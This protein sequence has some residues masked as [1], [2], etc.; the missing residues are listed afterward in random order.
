M[1]Y[2]SVS[3]ANPALV[4]CVVDCS[5]SMEDSGAHEHVF[6]AI[7]ELRFHALAKPKQIHVHIIGF[8]D[9]AQ[10][11]WQGWCEDF[12]PP[13][14]SELQRY[15][16]SQTHLKGACS[17]AVEAY[18]HHVSTRCTG[19]APLVNV[20]FFTDGFHSISLDYGDDKAIHGRTFIEVRKPNHWKSTTPDGLL[21]YIIGKPNV[22]LGLIDYS[23]T[24]RQFP[25]SG[26]SQKFPSDKITKTTI[27]EEGVLSK[28]YSRESVNPPPPGS[29]LV[30]IFGAMDNLLGK[31][32]IVSSDTI[33]QSPAVT[34]AFVR[35]GT[36][37][38][39]SSQN[40]N[41]ADDELQYRTDWN[42]E[43]NISFGDL[44]D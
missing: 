41:T 10:P 21:Q 18:K 2:D 28:A 33:L 44:E 16:G 36:S 12:I 43:W 37:T 9:H 11:I 39:F 1:N 8:S 38:A 42:S 15:A 29:S 25:G 17:A 13:G 34:S 26:F 23:G 14:E 19:D 31:R 40:L 24:L 32:F 20:L 3:R 27:L 35:L 30:E 7:S 5:P 6:S 22:L 4:L